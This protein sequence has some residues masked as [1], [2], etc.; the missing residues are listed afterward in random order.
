MKVFSIF[1]LISSSSAIRFVDNMDE[2]DM[3][4]ADIQY[5]RIE[6][7][8]SQ[9]TPEKAEMLQILAQKAKDSIVKVSDG[10]MIQTQDVYDEDLTLAEGEKVDTAAALSGE[11]ERVYNFERDVTTART[12]DK[13]FDNTAKKISTFMANVRKTYKDP[14]YLRDPITDPMKTAIRFKEDKNKREFE[15]YKQALDN[16]KTK[17][18]IK[19]SEEVA[20][21][22]E[23]SK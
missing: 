23:E 14:E 8:D 3:V 13:N 1:L 16:M 22:A 20:K 6:A 7:Q 15:A 21:Q 12:L 2:I 4:M 9:M 18:E 11:I 19:Q 17:Y 10:L 5:H